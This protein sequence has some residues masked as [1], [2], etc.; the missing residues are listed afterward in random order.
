MPP[1]M[2]AS[3][4]RRPVI[5]LV[6]LSYVLVVALSIVFFHARSNRLD[7]RIARE[8]VA[9]LGPSWRSALFELSRP[10][11]ALALLGLLVI[12]ALLSGR[13]DVAVLA[14]AGPSI[15]LGITELVLKPLVGRHWLN[16][17]SLSFPSGHETGVA[18]AAIV[19]LVASC[20][21]RLR[22]W[23]RALTV[24]V[25]TTWVVL[26]AVGLVRRPVHYATDTIG[27]VALSAAVVLTIA[28]VIDRAAAG[29]AWP[30]AR[31][32]WRRS[33]DRWGPRRRP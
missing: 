21:L 7:S 23:H 27:A 17:A 15:A 4:W 30:R 19:L 20:Q 10:V 9:H 1:P 31:W 5:L 22:A 24:A 2:I 33:P 28:L 14:I 25:L 13:S 8:L 18:S 26:A 32:R 16:S 11:I 6:T 29:R 3:S 12:A